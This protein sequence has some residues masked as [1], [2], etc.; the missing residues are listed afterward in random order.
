MSTAFAKING[1]VQ[2][3][4]RK[5]HNLNSD[6]IH[7][8]LA[9]TMTSGT[10]TAFT[11]GSTDLATGNGYTQGGQNLATPAASQSS[12]TLT[13]SVATTPIVWT[14]TGT[15]T[16]RYVLIVNT[17]ANLIIGYYDYG[18]SLTV[19]SGET[20]TFTPGASILTLV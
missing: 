8:C 12:G 2:D 10:S 11:A 3:V 20:F 9:T 4:A 15:L 17:T 16:F 13:F 1:F 7:A 18:S 6:T 14:S 5:L 19:N